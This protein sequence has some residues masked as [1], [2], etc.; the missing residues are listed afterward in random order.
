MFSHF[1]PPLRFR[2]Q[3]PTFA[4]R[5]TDVSRTANVGTVGIN[6]LLIFNESIIMYRG[7]LLQ[8]IR[9]ICYIYDAL[10]K[11]LIQNS[12]VFIGNN[13]LKYEKLLFKFRINNVYLEYLHKLWLFLEIVS[14][15]KIRKLNAY[16][17][18]ANQIEKHCARTLLNKRNN[19]IST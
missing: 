15:M 7:G 14:Q 17:V 6:V 10:G 13:S 3:V 5:E 18:V 2:N 1:Y 11:N 4:V 16:L 19:Q 9:Q 8:S 12:K